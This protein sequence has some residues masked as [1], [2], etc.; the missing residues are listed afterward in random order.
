MLIFI[1]FK[2]N[3]QQFQ[4]VCYFMLKNPQIEMDWGF[5]TNPAVLLACSL[6]PNL[7]PSPTSFRKNIESH[8]QLDAKPE[9]DLQISVPPQKIFKGPWT[10]KISNITRYAERMVRVASTNFGGSSL[11]RISRVSYCIYIES[12]SLIYKF[13]FS[14]KNK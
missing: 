12:Q 14:C 7:L 9:V 11:D 5:P 13:R 2:K 10:H 4:L 8:N 6:E 3:V 1:L